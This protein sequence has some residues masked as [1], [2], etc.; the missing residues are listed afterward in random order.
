ML[1]VMIL[2]VHLNVCLCEDKPF[3]V[4][5]VYCCKTFLIDI[6]MLFSFMACTCG[7]CNAVLMKFFLISMSVFIYC[8]CQW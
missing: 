8:V 2:Q 3:S 1:L 4:V 6:L 7:C 5:L